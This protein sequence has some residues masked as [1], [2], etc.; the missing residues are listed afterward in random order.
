M[1]AADPLAPVATRLTSVNPAPADSHHL[2]RV[3][4][5][6]CRADDKGRH[7]L[8][9]LERADGRGVAELQV[10]P[11]PSRADALIVEGLIVADDPAVDL[12]DAGSAQRRRPLVENGRL[13]ACREC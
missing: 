8:V 5:L 11:C 13:P 3:T 9:E 6:R 2:R 1:V 12:L 4:R 10:V 7:I